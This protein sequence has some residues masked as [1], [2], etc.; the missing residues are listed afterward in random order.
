MVK[1]RNYGVDLLRLVLMFMVCILHTLKQGGILQACEIGTLDHK[2]YW[3][4]EI[5]A[6][7]AVDGFAIISGYMAIDKPRKYE[8]LAEMWF[9]AFFYSFIVTLVFTI[10]GFQESWTVKEIIKCAL[11][12]T[13]GKFWY[14]TAF[15]AL[16]L[17]IPIL[18]RFIFGIDEV[19][20]KKTLIVLLVLFSVM[21]TATD[22][23][24]TNEGYSALWLV[25]LYCIGALA[26]KI[27][28]FETKKSSVLILVWAACI[29]LTWGIYVFVGND[30][31]IKYV[32]PTILLSGMIMVVLF[33]R[34]K[35]KG[36]L[37]SK[38]SPLA[39]GIYLFQINQV[40]WNNILKDAFAFVVSKPIALGVVYVFA[41][42]SLIFVSGLIV[43]FLRSKIAK[44]IRIPDLSKRIV[45]IIDEC[46]IKLLVILR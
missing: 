10:L 34:I 35:L 25:V 22:P 1:E 23:F 39:F 38:L 9:Q 26:K 21:G 7:C 13:F 24:K 6:Y 29:V 45:E 14:F 31:L 44:W 30:E 41:F 2:V 46:M 20:A 15:F 42:A 4:I 19:F 40:I 12:V 33:A 16:F 27:K 11:P 28:L 17:A 36:T 32:S 3:F 5:L 8:K 43:E 18:N 37:I